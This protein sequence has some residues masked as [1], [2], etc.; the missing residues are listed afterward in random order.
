MADTARP[1]GWPPNVPT[2]AEIDELT[3]SQDCQILARRRLCW[4][5]EDA[6]ARVEEAVE[7]ERREHFRRQKMNAAVIRDGHPPGENYF[8]CNIL[9]PI[10]HP[11]LP[12]EATKKEPPLAVRDLRAG[13][14]KHATVGKRGVCRECGSRCSNPRWIYDTVECRLAARKKRNLRACEECKGTL[15]EGS[16]KD[17]RF[18][19][20][21]CKLRSVRQRRKDATSF[22]SNAGEPGQHG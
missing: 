16:R 19:S 14:S 22:T 15:P 21:R 9:C 11:E 12:E 2:Q 7:I 8:P 3:P 17:K 1:R 20:N 6:R 5:Q 10:C 13:V 4:I 18:C